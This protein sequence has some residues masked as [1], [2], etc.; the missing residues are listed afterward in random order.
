LQISEGKVVS[1]VSGSRLYKIHIQIKPL[2]PKKWKNIIHTC[3]GKIDSLIELLQGRLSHS[4]MEVLT[5]RE[6]GMFPSP[7]QISL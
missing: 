6:A 1:Q 5:H 2:D 7:K 3:A 4:V